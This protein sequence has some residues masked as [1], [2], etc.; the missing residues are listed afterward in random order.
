MSQ[1]NDSDHQGYG[2][3]P[4][5]FDGSIDGR[6]VTQIGGGSNSCLA[7]SVDSTSG[8]TFEANDEQ[9]RLQTL[10]NYV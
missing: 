1:L 2:R 10:A 5:F 8:S 3:P 7:A 6:R 9:F 4:D